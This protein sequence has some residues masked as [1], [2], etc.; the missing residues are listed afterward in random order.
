MKH[1]VYK[2]LGLLSL[3]IYTLFIGCI[4]RGAYTCSDSIKL[5][6]PDS[7][8]RPWIFLTNTHVFWPH[9]MAVGDSMLYLLGP[10]RG[11]LLHVFNRHT[12]IFNGMHITR[13]RQI[14]QLENPSKIN[15]NIKNGCFDI[16]DYNYDY[17]NDINYYSD[18]FKY[19]KTIEINPNFTN[20]HAFFDLYTGHSIVFTPIYDERGYWEQ[21]DMINLIETQSGKIL[22]TI[23]GKEPSDS[24]SPGIIRRYAISPSK[25]AFACILEG[26]G[27][28]ELYKI[29]N[30]S[31]QRTF[32]K[33]YFLEEYIYTKGH[34]KLNCSP[35]KQYGFNSI[36]ADDNYI[37]ISY[38]DAIENQHTICNIGV[39][40]WNGNPVKKITTNQNP[41]I[42]RVSP[43][44]KTIYS[45]IYTSNEDFTLSYINI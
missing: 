9:D 7:I 18:N 31:I 16:Y 12:G 27:S 41:I 8:K 34:K 4:N 21:R 11:Y 38:L 3:L 45:V 40:D 6:F 17:T 20:L 32:V 44:G 2:K 29:S 26:K 30:Q 15:L 35:K 13:G 28:L 33:N 36:T 42:I 10:Y 37:Y 22:S 14:G 5:T 43:D 1:P 19:L 23:E 25:T 39:W 24:L